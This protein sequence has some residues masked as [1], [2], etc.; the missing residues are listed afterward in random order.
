[1]PSWAESMIRILKEEGISTPGDLLKTITP[2]GNIG[3]ADYYINTV[4]V[5][6]PQEALIENNGKL[7]L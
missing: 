7:C 5:R 6:L 4:G 3:A 1:M 2:L